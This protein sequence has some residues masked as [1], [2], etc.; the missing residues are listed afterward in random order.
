MDSTFE[1]KGEIYH[2]RRDINY[3]NEHFAQTEDYYPYYDAL[4]EAYLACSDE[5]C[6]LYLAEGL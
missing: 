2:I 3:A 1:Y 5:I 4:M 6:A